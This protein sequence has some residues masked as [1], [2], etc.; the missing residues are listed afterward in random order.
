MW[1]RYRK[2]KHWAIPALVA[3]CL[4]L[5]RGEP[6]ESWRWTVGMVLAATLGL[7][8]IAEELVWMKISKGRPCKHCGQMVPLKPFRLALK[9]PNC[10]KQFD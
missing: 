5:M 2:W 4:L 10:G 8:Y 3:I 6:D 9:C 7:L 1:G